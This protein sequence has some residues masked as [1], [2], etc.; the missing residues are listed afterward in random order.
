MFDF[1]IKLKG[2]QLAALIGA[3]IGI[4]VAICLGIGAA[5]ADTTP[6]MTWGEVTIDG[7]AAPQGTTIEVYIGDDIAPSGN[8]TV[9]TPGLYGAIVVWGDDSKWGEPLTYKVNSVAAVKTGPDPGVFGLQN[10]V[11][12][13][14]ELMDQP[15]EKVW[16]FNAPGCMP[17]H[18]PDSYMG[19]TALQELDPE[20][21]PP[22]VQ[23]VYLFLDDQL[24]WVFWAPG[25]PGC[26][27]A[28]LWGGMFDDYMVCVTGPCE[29]TIPLDPSP[30]F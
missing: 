20:S 3:L 19:A 29:W 25:A 10:Q 13:L 11:V 23:G 17:R 27:L 2:W 14:M 26:E 18:L 5:L 16:S 28:Y 4:C 22:E 24:R 8:Y 15:T 12:N 1:L 30:R 21:I 7:A 9:M 6:L